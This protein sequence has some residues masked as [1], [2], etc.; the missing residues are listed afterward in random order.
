MNAS[1]FSGFT[2]TP[3]GAALGCLALLLLPTM[4]VGAL[5]VAERGMDLTLLMLWTTAVVAAVAAALQFAWRR[6]TIGA[7]HLFGMWLMMGIAPM[8]NYRSGLLSE[9]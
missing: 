9:Q 1:I 5:A 8:L 2:A 6:V 7:L 4:A 3:A